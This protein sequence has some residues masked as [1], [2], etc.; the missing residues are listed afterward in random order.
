MARPVD[1]IRE[2][3]SVNPSE[4]P[5]KS[6]GELFADLSRETTTLVR[7]EVDLAKTEMSKKAAEVGKDVG[8]LA[9][10]GLVAY[11]G[12]LALVAALIV[13]LGQLG[14]PWWI[15]AL[16]VGVA[17]SGLG[18]YLVMQGLTNLK[19]ISLAPTQTIETLREDGQWAKN[20]TS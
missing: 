9:A 7:Q 10:G 16:L 4:A 6:L 20:Q 17:V 1:H 5:D 3:R 2:S 12:F 13:G 14:L 15:S 8:F 18:G 19:H 11:A